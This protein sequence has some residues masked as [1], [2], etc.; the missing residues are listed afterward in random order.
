MHLPAFGSWGH[1]SFVQAMRFSRLAALICLLLHEFGETG[2]EA[3]THFQEECCGRGSLTSGVLRFGLAAAR[4]DAS[5]LSVWC[6]FAS[7]IRM[8]PAMDLLSGLGFLAALPA[9]QGSDLSVSLWCVLRFE[10]Y[11]LRV[12]GG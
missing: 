6:A 9:A 12:C 3:V 11:A 4:R 1:P 7:E 8:D 10:P 5:W 2:P